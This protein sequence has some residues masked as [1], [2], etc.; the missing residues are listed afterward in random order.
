MT[1]KAKLV[2]ANEPFPLHNTFDCHVS[3]SQLK[4]TKKVKA[5]FVFERLS[6]ANNGQSKS[7]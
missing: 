1:N 7:N 3:Y 5:L 2:E 4:G 6:D